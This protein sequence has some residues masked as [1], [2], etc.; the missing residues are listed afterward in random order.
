VSA[1]ARASAERPYDEAF[2]APGVPRPHY[3][4]LV[5]T[6]SGMDLAALRDGVNARVQAEGVAFT[7]THGDEAFVVDPVP[8]ILT[9]DE[10][11]ALA[12]GLEQRVRALNAFVTDA[13]G[14][15]R[16]VD[17][18]VVPAE[19]ID[20]AE[21]YE[22]ALR[23]RLPGGAPPVGLAGLDIVRGPDGVLRV[24]EDN[25]RMPSG[26]TYAVAARRAVES[27][28]DGRG[29][30]PAPIGEALADLLGEVL[31]AAAPA[32]SDA[33]AVVV[34]DGPSGSAWYE[35][36]EVARLLDV[37]VVTPAELER[38]GD[39]LAV[40]LEDGRRTP[41]DVVYRRCDEDRLHDGSGALTPLAEVLLEPWLAG[42]IGIVNGF[43]TGV[44]DDK[45][46]HAYVDEMI[47]FYLGEEPLVEAVPTLDPSRPGV[48]DDVLADLRSLVVKPRMGHGGTGVVICAHAGD[49]EVERLAAELRAEPSGFVAQPIVLLSEHPTIVDPGRLEPRHVDLRPYVFSTPTAVRS[50]PGGVTRVAW[51]RGALVVNASQ[52][53]GAKDTWV[54]NSGA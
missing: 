10:W 12:A 1:A 36:R 17:A 13:Y 45:L 44:G 42:R 11:R 37:P 25:L 23:H 16:I 32:G 22:P 48:L 43:G 3:A 18:G 39:L 31:R 40:R 19:V 30:A 53:G 15:R 6:L 29:P 34:C 21:G 5:G 49:A 7:S 50:L 33:S 27:A 28:L 4:K 8:R 14:E 24:L 54:L 47:R 20:S 51:D 46:V 38:R 52:N 35:H 2:A 41:V 9:A 26:F